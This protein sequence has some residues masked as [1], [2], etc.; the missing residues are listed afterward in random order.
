[1]LERIVENWL[2][3]SGEL[4]Y[5][6]AFSQL[7]V[8]ERYRVLHAAV[9]HPYE[10][11]KDIV[12]VSP[13]GALNAF[14][15]KGGDIGLS[16]LDRLQ[17]QLF[18]LA[19][20]AVTYPGVEPP[21]PPDRV[22]LVTNGRLSAP[23]R[24]RLRSFNDA[25]RQR[26]FPAIETVE[27]DQ[28]VGRFVHAH[29]SFLPRDLSDLNK[30]L[31]IVLSTGEGPFPVRDFAEMI[32]GIL[33][34]SD[35]TRRGTEATRA[36]ASAGIF[37][38]YATGPWQRA[39]NHTGVA[40]GWL[41][42]ALSILRCAE[43]ENLDE[44][45]WQSSFEIARGS[46]QQALAAL[47]N[48]AASAD[49]LVIPDIVDGLVYPARATLVCGYVAA[50]FLSE[51][52]ERDVSELVEPV[53]RVLLRELEYLQMPGEAGAAFFLM[54]ATALEVLGEVPAA[55]KLILQWAGALTITNAPDSAGGAPDPYHSFEEVLRFQLGTD[56][57][58]EEENFLGEAYTLHIAL[59]W[60]ARRDARIVVEKLWPSVTKLHFA[61]THTSSPAGLLAHNDPDA[62]LE[63]WAPAAP[64]S[65]AK[66]VETACI[67][68]EGKLPMRLWQQLGVLPYLPLLYPYRLTREVAM[69]LDYMTTGRC[70][71]RL[72]EDDADHA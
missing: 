36:I 31:A 2:T 44:S 57:V 47:L 27:R 34:P 40:E 42:L 53:R 54:I 29:G 7:L 58:L 6:A 19:G 39:A 49:D 13:D 9:H 30:L 60:F 32:W 17:G 59:D 51:R 10:H 72:L 28:L 48:D 38:S 26:G 62:T 68:D 67:V 24:D 66:L 45:T 41:V 61:E 25:N 12:G 18:T 64:A 15:L 55:L 50:Y 22:F 71:V 63:T 16:E 20:T 5:Q 4:G 1:M 33:R 3:S 56:A 69:A 43:L 37:T 52:F 70:S 65:W 46:A 21:R 23:A 14:Q 11:G 8:S 35:S